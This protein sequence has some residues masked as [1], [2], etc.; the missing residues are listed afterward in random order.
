MSRE[1]E[2]GSKIGYG[3][4]A[5]AGNAMRNY[6]RRYAA[7]GVGVYQ[8]SHCDKWHWGHRPKKPR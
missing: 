4:K 6:K 5:E 3:S 2:C 8:C 7:R 1:R